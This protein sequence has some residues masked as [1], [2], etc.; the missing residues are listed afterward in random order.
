MTAPAAIRDLAVGFLWF[1]WHSGE[2]VAA[3]D[4]RAPR[5]AR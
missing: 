1:G 4:E 5:L 2:P 3:L